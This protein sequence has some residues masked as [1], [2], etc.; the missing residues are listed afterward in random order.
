MP[1]GG[2]RHLNARMP[3]LVADELCT[4]ALRYQK[5]CK[6]MPQ[7]VE[8][9]HG[10][11][12]ASKKRSDVDELPDKILGGWDDWPGFKLRDFQAAR[13]IVVNVPVLNG[14]AGVVSNQH[15]F[16]QSHDIAERFA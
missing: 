3:K 4:E 8:T 11:G 13:R 7:L 9:N 16:Q 1:V 14:A 2:E 6:E 12:I 15:H 5:R 10:V